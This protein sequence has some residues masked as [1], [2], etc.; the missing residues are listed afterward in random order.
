MSIQP[1]SQQPVYVTKQLSPEV[2]GAATTSLWL[3]IIFGIFSLL[4]IGHVYSGRTA[5]GG[6]YNEKCVKKRESWYPCR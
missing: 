6:W 5:L 4:G 3:E 2:E 1:E